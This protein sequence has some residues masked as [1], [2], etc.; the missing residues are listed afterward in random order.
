[1]KPDDVADRILDA[2]DPT[3]AQV[4]HRDRKKPVVATLT[5]TPPPRQTEKLYEVEGV[6]KSLTGWSQEAGIAKPTLHHRV[7][8]RRMT[9]A[10][11]VAIGRPSYR[12]R[13][14]MTTAAPPADCATD[15]KVSADDE[16]SDGQEAPTSKEGTPRKSAENPVNSAPHTITVTNRSL[17]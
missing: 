17:S 10:E 5:S 9:V 6:S 12:K 13:G 16:A 7:M 4:A 8:T 1:V 3:Y 2:I 14:P 15:V 11:A